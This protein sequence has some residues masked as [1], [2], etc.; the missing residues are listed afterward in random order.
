L[1]TDTIL[2]F[3]LKLQ[4]DRGCFHREEARARKRRE[5]GTRKRKRK[6]KR[7]REHRT[8]AV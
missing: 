5:S 3:V 2:N 8:F 7:K 4:V 6:R 1:R